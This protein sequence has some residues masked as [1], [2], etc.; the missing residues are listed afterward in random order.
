MAL[1]NWKP[2]PLSWFAKRE[3]TEFHHATCDVCGSTFQWLETGV[4]Y[5]VPMVGSATRQKPEAS[6]LDIGGWCLKCHRMICPNEA[7]FVPFT[8]NGQDWWVA[9]CR[10]CQTPLGGRVNRES[11]YAKHGG[12]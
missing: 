4:V 5:P 8:M 7:D 1:F 6:V 2:K 11:F 9:G 12:G 3:G 10:D